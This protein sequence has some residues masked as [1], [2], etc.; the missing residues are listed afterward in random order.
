[1]ESISKEEQLAPLL[2]GLFGYAST[3]NYEV[4]E[5][6]TETSVTVIHKIEVPSKVTLG[7]HVKFILYNT[8]GYD[9]NEIEHA[10]ITVYDL[11]VMF[12]KSIEELQEQRKKVKEILGVEDEIR[13]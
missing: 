3:K 11:I 9:D 5:H 12:N 6:P 13:H 4:V 2:S 8:T 1:M 7:S 10:S